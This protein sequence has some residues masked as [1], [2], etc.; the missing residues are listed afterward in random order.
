MKQPSPATISA[1]MRALGSRKS[2]AKT[3]A[4]QRN[5]KRAG[6]PWT[7]DKC[8]RVFPPSTR[9]G[10]RGMTR[11]GRWRQCARCWKRRKS[12]S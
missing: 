3:A 2:P 11:A 8:R 6:R 5:A 10:A 1:V 9:P 7:C 4:A 12:G